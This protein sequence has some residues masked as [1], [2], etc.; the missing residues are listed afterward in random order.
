MDDI[1]YMREALKEAEK[2]MQRGEIPVGALL[3]RNGEI[4]GRGSNSR[5]SGSLGHAE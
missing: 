2:A 5:P 3:V 4:I 1:H